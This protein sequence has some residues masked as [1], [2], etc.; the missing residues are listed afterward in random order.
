MKANAKLGIILTLGF[1][2]VCWGSASND[3]LHER[4]DQLD[5][6]I[7]MSDNTGPINRFRRSLDEF[8]AI[9]KGISIGLVIDTTGS[10]SGEIAEVKKFAINLLNELTNAPGNRICDLVFVPTND[11]RR[12]EEN[13]VKT[14]T[15]NVLTKAIENIVA[16]GG[17][18]CPERT[19]VGVE[20][21][22]DL[23]YDGSFIF[24][25][26]DADPN[27]AYLYETIKNK[28]ERKKITIYFLLT[29][30]CDTEP[31]ESF[32]KLAL[33]RGM[34]QLAHIDKN[35]SD[36]RNI[37]QSLKDLFQNN[38]VLLGSE[39][40]PATTDEGKKFPV[41]V[42]PKT[43][44]LRLT[45]SGKDIEVEL[46]DPEGSTPKNITTLTDVANFKIFSIS[47]PAPG[48]WTVTLKS[49]SDYKVVTSAVSNI[50][51]EYGFSTALTEDI[52][53]VAKSPGKDVESYL[54]LLVSSPT[55]VF[56]VS[57]VDIIVGS[58]IKESLIVDVVDADKGI[59]RAKKIIYPNESFSIRI[60][61]FTSDGH[62]FTRE[63]L[64]TIQSQEPG[65]PVIE[66]KDKM[67]ASAGVAFN[68][69]CSVETQTVVEVR[70]Y[71]EGSTH[72]HTD[73]H[74]ETAR[75]FISFPVLLTKDSG[76]YIIEA[77]N[78]KGRET[79]KIQ[80]K[81]IENPPKASINKALFVVVAGVDITIDCRCDSF[82]DCT[83][84]WTKSDSPADHFSQKPALPLLSG[85]NVEVGKVDVILTPA[86][87]KDAGWYI[88][89]ARNG[90]GTS[91]A[92]TYLEVQERPEVEILDSSKA[93]VSLVTFKQWSTVTITCSAKK[94]VPPPRLDWFRHNRPISESK[95]TTI[96]GKNYVT[97]TIRNSQ[98]H[99]Q[100]NYTCS[101]FN[102]VGVDEKYVTLQ[103]VQK[104]RIS[105]PSTY[106]PTFLVGFDAVL[107]CYFDGTPTPSITWT[108][109]K[110]DSF[111]TIE[112]RVGSHAKAVMGT[113]TL[114]LPNVTFEDT[115]T[116]YCE[117]SNVA[118]SQKKQMSLRVEE[119][120]AFEITTDDVTVP[121]YGTIELPCNPKGIPVPTIAWRK[122]DG[123]LAGKIVGTNYIITNA[124]LEEQGVYVC[125][126]ENIHGG[127]EF[128]V[129]V[130]ISG[131]APPKLY[132]DSKS[133][134]QKRL[135]G[136]NITLN[137]P[138]IQGEPVPTLTW[139][140]SGRTIRNGYP[141]TISQEYRSLTIDPVSEV[142]TG[143][144][145]CIAENQL[146]KDNKTYTL[147]LYKPPII[148]QP[149]GPTFV[150]TEERA[151]LICSTEADPVA[152]VN[153]FQVKKKQETHI[154]QVT[155]LVSSKLEVPEGSVK[156]RA[157]YLCRASNS[158]GVAEKVFEVVV[159]KPPR[160]K[161]RWEKKIRQKGD[162]E[163]ML[164]CTASGNPKPI[165]TWT[166]DGK[167]VS[168]LESNPIYRVR[169]GSGNYGCTASNH[170]G[171]DVRLTLIERF[172]PPEIKKLPAVT[173]VRNG[174][175][176]VLNC[177]VSGFP[178]PTITW[179]FNGN[180]VVRRRG[181][182]YEIPKISHKLEG[183]YTCIATNSEG[184]AAGT[185]R[186]VV[187]DAPIINCEKPSYEVRFRQLA[188]FVC[189]VKANPRATIKWY[190]DGRPWG[191]SY[192]D[193]TL[194]FV[195]GEH[196]AGLFKIEAVNQLG[197][198][199]KE[200]ELTVLKPPT[201]SPSHVK[202]ITVTTGAKAVLPCQADGFPQP[203]SFWDVLSIPDPRKYSA[204]SGSL[205]IDDVQIDD[206]GD[207]KCIAENKVGSQIHFIHLSVAEKPKVTIVTKN[208]QTNGDV[209]SGDDVV[210]MCNVKGK[211]IPELSWFKDDLHLSTDRVIRFKASE[212]K[213][214]NYICK[215]SNSYGEANDSISI[216]ALSSPVIT[217]LPYE[218]LKGT[219][220][221]ALELSCSAS[222]NPLPSISW[223]RNDRKLQNTPET[224]VD[225]PKLRISRL[226]RELSGNITCEA[227]NSRGK[228][229]KK[230][231]LIVNT[232]PKVDDTVPKEIPI[233]FNT[234]FAV[235]CKAEGSPKPFIEWAAVIGGVSRVLSP[236]DSYNGFTVLPDGTL[237]GRNVT[238]TE[239]RNVSCSASN[240][241]GTDFSRHVLRVSELP[242]ANTTILKLVKRIPSAAVV[243]T[244]QG[245]RTV[246]DCPSKPMS[247]TSAPWLKNF[248]D[249]SP[250]DYSSGRY[251]L[252]DNGTKL[253]V[254]FPDET[255]I[256]TFTCVDS[257]SGRNSFILN[258][259]AEPHF[260]ESAVTEYKVVEN[261]QL[262]VSCRAGG[263]PL[264]LVCQSLIVIQFY[265]KT[266]LSRV[267]A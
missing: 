84:E 182:E 125:R 124:A 214:G 183:N 242:N 175:S 110:G 53:G 200:I 244:K 52:K 196:D 11:E 131:T 27:D 48:K 13:Y 158:V 46:K 246:L 187:T 136:S 140:H 31:A 95:N 56:N 154:P 44:E 134:V 115:G 145:T 224:K 193:G 59:F 42:P 10:M 19:L 98:I 139:I 3:T 92:K 12:T 89:T 24:V 264:P 120:P 103:F 239:D 113:A 151:K 157:K 55:K 129:K 87:S 1:Q 5:S 185:T 83:I 15:L 121:L 226:S 135:P 195:V 263:N 266:F 72:T 177:P 167:L 203:K 237:I 65:P 148:I 50:N 99:N 112:G 63:S 123:N 70:M 94:G 130:G 172:G 132:K 164:N 241:A 23:S 254:N 102:D 202:E 225:G 64:T 255:D 197:R 168:A 245:K 60:T 29:G 162:D 194:Q 176:V 14:R 86:L 222:G 260:L 126:A 18:T 249:I 181:P 16:D 17:G 96:R 8:C 49:K 75:V 220:G 33:G 91:V 210:L 206:E 165:Y 184:S 232:S 211:P 199:F 218:Q 198:H 179:R 208:V 247:Y 111:T 105:R 133:N 41:I 230:F 93:P 66:C 6:H 71:K 146:G 216:N 101:G 137:C 82:T 212:S 235:P 256:A 248:R 62:I 85:E 88:C 204:E 117:A 47:D 250:S 21:A 215:A 37:I 227:L 144:Y 252:L 128:R 163:I 69:T 189:E 34:S 107:I 51:I 213:S 259:M 190:K 39:T 114:T 81:V 4:E 186:L 28:M 201:F 32:V 243:T 159:I 233:Y 171:K 251:R 178:A 54:L 67:L 61:A 155:S 188:N 161:V 116:Y 109:L 9:E 219:E 142:V 119:K 231:E 36:L 217:G 253:S 141:Y 173:Q 79:K 150:R 209:N 77:T 267:D 138:I 240:I 30:V 106:K 80:L 180:E 265:Y 97:L 45:G 147:A 257:R 261:D 35:P 40:G 118:G 207:Y 100:G 152:T 76:N 205:A 192:Q 234:E 90:G 149:A 153:W 170:F 122:I 57:V 26:T 104:P 223:F 78:A 156:R 262:D 169:D 43:P 191:S 20:K 228:F 58:S 258:V 229:I 2:A 238:W 38:T 73:R 108:R 68:M 221:H 166:H 74:Q 143:N 127:A 174:E 236:G 7:W 22:I 25:F 160:I